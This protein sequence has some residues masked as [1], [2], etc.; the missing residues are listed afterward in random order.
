MSYTIYS[1]QLPAP[2]QL[3]IV[4]LLQTQKKKW[5]KC[6]LKFRE[7]IGLDTDSELA[8]ISVAPNRVGLV[9]VWALVRPWP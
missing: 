1:K 4:K 5:R 6:N 3:L 9:K 2:A 8:T 7:H